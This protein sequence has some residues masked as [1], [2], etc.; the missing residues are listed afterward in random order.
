MARTKRDIAARLFEAGL[1]NRPIHAML[2]NNRHQPPEDPRGRYVE[3]FIRYDMSKPTEYFRTVKTETIFRFF[4]TIEE[5]D[6]K[7]FIPTGGLTPGQ[8]MRII[9]QFWDK[10]VAGPNCWGKKDI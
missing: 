7:I 6:K 5:W 9:E 1:F 10:R 8:V 3:I 4:C 2:F